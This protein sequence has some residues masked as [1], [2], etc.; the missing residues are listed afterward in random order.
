LGNVKEFTREENNTMLKKHY[1][2]IK[3]LLKLLMCR[4]AWWQKSGW[5]PNWSDD[6]YK[7]CIE[8]FNDDIRCI[9]LNKTSCILAFESMEIRDKFLDSFRDDIEKAKTLL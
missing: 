7:Y 8:S 1:D 3:S 5:E 2:A 9:A 4:D 6:T